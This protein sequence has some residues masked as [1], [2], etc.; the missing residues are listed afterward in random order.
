MSWVRVTRLG[1][2]SACLLL[3]WS[4]KSWRQRTQFIIF[5]KKTLRQSCVMQ[6]GGGVLFL[7]F[8]NMTSVCDWVL[9]VCAET[10]RK[11]VFWWCS[12]VPDR[13][14]AR[15]GEST[16]RH[17]RSSQ[18]GKEGAEMNREL[19]LFCQREM[20]FVASGGSFDRF[21]TRRHLCHSA[22]RLWRWKAMKLVLPFQ[23]GVHFQQ[24]ATSQTSHCLWF[25]QLLSLHESHA[26]F[27][28]RN[29]WRMRTSR[30]TSRWAMRILSPS[31]CGNRRR[32]RRMLAFSEFHAT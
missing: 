30:S 20:C 17:W 25:V 19:F 4:T 22:G 24:H 16:R 9:T 5:G 14:V 11:R 32:S 2:I 21:Q 27:L 10:R 8:S 23:L 26:H 6:R 31:R 18:R 1:A 29:T 15:F 7:Y 3:G 13:E 28:Y 12:K